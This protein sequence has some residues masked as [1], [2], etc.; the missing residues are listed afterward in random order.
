MATTVRRRPPDR[1]AQIARAAAV[2]FG[3]AGY[4]GVGIDDVAAVV[5][6]TGGAVYR[7]FG[8]KYEL[9]H[10]A[11][12]DGIGL[13]EAAVAPP[14][15]LSDLLARL[16]D[17]VLDRRDLGVLLQRESRHLD[18]DDQA[19]LRRRVSG[20]AGH[21]TPFLRADDTQVLVR[22]MFAVLA[23][24]SYHRATLP[25]DAGAA[26]LIRMLTA[27]AHSG[28][29]SWRKPT[30]IASRMGSGVVPVRA[31]RRE[32]LLS[33]AGPLFAR[34]GY[35]AVRMEDVGAAAGIAG[36]SI[37]QHFESKADLLTAALTRGAEWLQFGLSRALAAAGSETDALERV[38][39]SYA[40]FVLEQP[41]LV[42]LL[43]TETINLPD[44]QRHTIRRLQHDYVAEWVRLVLAVRSDCTDREARFLTQG[45]LGIVNDNARSAQ[46]RSHPNL[47]ATLTQLGL[48]VLHA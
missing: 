22:S 35:A 9:L 3:Q 45:V 24:P 4:F 31:S 42:A 15:E 28:G 5:G 17:L 29:N 18:P 13:V 10:R 46:A 21:I 44:A 19:E 20:V 32:M 40:E 6:I 36:P 1:K 8:N 23:S 30:V 39:G 12:F 26:V 33:V 16:A 2:S 41:D 48:E 47:Q 38:V 25:G 27:V 34:H 37:Y 7:H 43:L 14:G 11:V